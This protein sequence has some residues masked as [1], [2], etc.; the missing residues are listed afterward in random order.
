MNQLH[1]AQSGRSNT[2]AW[3]PPASSSSVAISAMLFWCND[4]AD[5]LHRTGSYPSAAD[6]GDYNRIFFSYCFPSGGGRHRR[7]HTLRP[8][9]VCRLPCCRRFEFRGFCLSCSQSAMKG[10]IKLVDLV[11]RDTIF[12]AGISASC[13]QSIPHYFVLDIGLMAWR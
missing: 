8:W 13:G 1:C 3:S 2:R 7:R 12:R 11:N 9:V 6:A 4:G 10:S 5:Q